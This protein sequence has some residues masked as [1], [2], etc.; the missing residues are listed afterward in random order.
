MI[1]FNIPPYIGNEINYIQDAIQNHKICSD[2]KY[3]NICSDWL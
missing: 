2:G 1:N 3:T